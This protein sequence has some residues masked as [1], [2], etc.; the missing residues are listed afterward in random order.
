M[1]IPVNGQLGNPQANG[2]VPV[3]VE[4]RL[5]NVFVEDIACGAYHV[6]VLT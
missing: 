3:H 1:G 5:H 6:V 2:K 4:G